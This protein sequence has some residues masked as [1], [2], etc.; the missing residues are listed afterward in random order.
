GTA[1]DNGHGGAI[2][3]Y[4]STSAY[5]TVSINN[6][7]FSG[8]TAADGGAIYDSSIALG[9]KN[10]AISGCSFSGNSAT[11][12]GA[13]YLD[14]SDV[15]ISNS[16]FVNNTATQRGG[17]IFVNLGTVLTVTQ[18]TFSGNTPNNIYGSYYDGGGNM[19][20]RGKP[21]TVSANEP[22]GRCVT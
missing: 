12:G 5:P 2:A 6:S 8:N 10:P 21:E 11:N 13:V 18:D 4:P 3:A 20:L 15:T 19:G 9:T 1:P 17:A 22:S 14:G 16:S 7:T